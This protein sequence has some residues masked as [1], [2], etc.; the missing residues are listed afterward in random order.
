MYM[1]IT[2]VFRQYILFSA[3]YICSECGLRSYSSAMLMRMSVLALAIKL[4]FL[5]RTED[6]SLC[7]NAVGYLI[8]NN[9]DVR[10]AVA[11]VMPI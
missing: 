10:F 11:V 2:R 5:V 3:A 4:H 7:F 1:G 8:F 6:P 9:F